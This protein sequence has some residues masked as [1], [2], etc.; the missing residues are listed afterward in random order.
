MFY[1]RHQL[2]FIRQS[3]VIKLKEQERLDAQ[4]RADE[5]KERIQANKRRQEEEEQQV[6]YS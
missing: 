6:C 3:D 5:E 4:R 1:G 2:K